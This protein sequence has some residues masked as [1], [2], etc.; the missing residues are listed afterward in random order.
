MKPQNT[1]ALQGRKRRQ[2]L[3]R[4]AGHFEATLAAGR[5][6]ASAATRVDLPY[7]PAPAEKEKLPAGGELKLS[8]VARPSLYLP[9]QF[10]ELNW[11]VLPAAAT[12]GA[13]SE[14][15]DVLPLVV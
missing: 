13:G 7:L 3:A 4:D 1:E 6:T 2:P 11:T 9:L 8:M 5:L 15:I 12:T 14:N 10:G